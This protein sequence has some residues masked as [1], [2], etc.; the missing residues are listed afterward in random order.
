MIIDNDNLA[1]AKFV[2]SIFKNNLEIVSEF[3]HVI[4][5]KFNPF[6]TEAV[7]I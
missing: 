7:I 2:S 4:L 6:M 3:L 5:S 1:I